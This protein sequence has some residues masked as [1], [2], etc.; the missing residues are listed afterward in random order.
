M[1]E[2]GVVKVT[3]SSTASTKAEPSIT[4]QTATTLLPSSTELATV[5]HVRLPG[6]WHHS[7]QQWFTHADAVF[8]SSRIRSDLSRVN[9]VLAS[10]DEDGIRAVSDILGEDA[11]YDAL[12]ARLISTYTVPRA[13]RF[14]SI[15][16]PGGMG[17][18]TPSRL[19]RD[20]RDVYPDDMGDASL[21][22]FW[23]Q[24]LPP[25]VRTVIAGLSGPLDA[26]AERADRVMEAARG[27]TELA[28]VNA[29]PRFRIAAVFPPSGVL[30]PEEAREVAA[31]NNNIDARFNALESA[32]HTLSAQVAT[33]TSNHPARDAPQ[34]PAPTRSNTTKA[35][36]CYYH[37]HYGPD[38]RKCRD[39]CTFV[40]ATLKNP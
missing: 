13:T 19:L 10:L 24:E 1:S 37:G 29:T 20:M 28:A 23:M 17:D 9:H 25:A 27:G 6:F 26:L 31:A 16:Q 35:G 39:P 11:K 8:H 40:P 32:I 30:E 36:W 15:M 22:Q 21:E 33:L 3:T 4:V 5:T 18:R 2:D 14:Q 7:P 38:A 12:R 34:P